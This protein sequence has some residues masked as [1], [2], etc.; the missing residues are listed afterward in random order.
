MGN[1]YERFIAER[2]LSDKTEAKIYVKEV[3]KGSIEADLVP[4]V[5]LF[6]PFIS[7]M[8]AV[9]L[10][11]DFV[12]RWGGRI[13]T[14]LNGTKDELPQTSG[15]LKDWARA[16]EAIAKDPDG[17]ATIKAA[18]FED[19]KRQIRAAVEFDTKQAKR[20]MNLIEERRQQIEHQSTGQRSRVL[21]VFTRSD[22]N[23]ADVG[24]RSGERVKI[25]ELSHKS[26]A[27][28]Y[29][30]EMAEER[31]KHEIR[32][33]DDNVFKKGFVVDVLIKQRNN[34]PVAYSVTHVHDVIDLPD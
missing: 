23:D 16:V 5:S 20:A 11:E 15:E 6:A 25:E 12:R 24:K 34:E 33:A 32:E 26:L 27:L 10:V 8:D 18:V 19:G 1:D 29:G 31:I 9:M 28:M 21:M 13:H 2:G 7:Q 4:W 30:S 3:R 17:K 14:L 22:V